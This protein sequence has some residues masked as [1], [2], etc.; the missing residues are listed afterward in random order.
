MAVL[1][2]AS[3]KK[4]MVDFLQA[5][6]ALVTLAGHTS[7]DPRIIGASTEDR[8]PDK[9]VFI[10]SRPAR[11]VVPIY[12]DDGPW[13]T[14]FHLYIRHTE[15]AKVYEMLGVIQEYVAQSLVTGADASYDGHASVRLESI[16]WSADLSNAPEVQ[17]DEHGFWWTDA[18]LV[19]RWRE[20]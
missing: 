16:R 3:T 17:Q 6:A 11:P 19:T 8:L 14:S 12:C 20:N 10:F 5:S 1:K 18:F 2:F 7:G 9:G 15:E 4:A 13:N